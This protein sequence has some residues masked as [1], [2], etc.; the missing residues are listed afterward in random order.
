MK[1]ALITL[2]ALLGFSCSQQNSAAQS[3]LDP[4]AFESG[5]AVAGAQLI[6]VRTPDEFQA[7]HIEGAQNINIASPQFGNET[8]KLNKAEPVY[9][10][11]AVGGRSA[12]AAS[13][14]KEQGFLQ[15][16]DLAGGITAWKSSGKK[17]V[18]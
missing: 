18:K 1:N 2:L 14:L 17:V 12:K 4:A 16:Y 7:G 6:D 5:M 11:C 8:G 3:K 10:Y 13:A 9:V 15:V